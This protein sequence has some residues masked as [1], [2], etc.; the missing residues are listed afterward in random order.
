MTK[1]IELKQPNL[2]QLNVKCEEVT[3]KSADPQMS[4]AMVMLATRFQTLQATAKVKIIEHVS[5]VSNEVL[6]KLQ[7]Q[8][9]ARNNFFGLVGESVY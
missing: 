4:S 8:F 3:L 1:E 9:I 5:W 2:E 6:N 7:S